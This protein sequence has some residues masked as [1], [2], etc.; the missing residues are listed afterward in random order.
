MQ[1]DVKALAIPDVKLIAP[2]RIE[3]DRG[4]FSETYSRKNLAA[5]GIADEFVQ[6]NHSL[7]R[8]VG[9]IRGL[10]FQTDPH[11][12]GKL[13]RVVRGAI[14]DVAVDIRQGSPTFGQHVAVELSA[15]N[16]LQLWVP[17]GFA[18]GFCT[19]IP[20]TEVIYKVTSSYAQASERGIAF[21]DPELAIAWPVAAGRAVVSAKDRGHPR[22]SA[23]PDHFTYP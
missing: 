3:D 7:S 22:F 20:E 11:A 17:I 8:S 10:H 19:L 4:Y 1:M 16:W 5:A 21:D 2:R 12:Q 9:V 6:D 23:L 18:H 14:F 15:D 13:V